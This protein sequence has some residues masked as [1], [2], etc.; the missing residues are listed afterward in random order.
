MENVYLVIISTHDYTFFTSYE[1]NAIGIME[2]LINNYALMYAF[3]NQIP[4]IN[5]N[6]IISGISPY[7]REDF[8]KIGIYSTPAYRIS[9]FKKNIQKRT[10]NYP[11]ILQDQK[12]IINDN[13]IYWEESEPVGFTYNSIEE[14]HTLKMKPLQ[15]NFPNL[16]CYYKIPPLS[17]FIC[18]T[19]GKKPPNFIRLGK[20]FVPC[21]VHSLL[22]KNIKLID[23]TFY[24]Y[25]PINL[26]ELSSESQIIE[27]LLVYLQPT[28]ILVDGKLKGKFIKGEINGFECIISIPNISL[29]PSVFQ[30]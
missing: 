28:S 27:G 2:N 20:K 30:L 6:R 11:E 12:A 29:Y 17:T 3:N 13:L 16:G 19:I 8:K 1:Y 24:P 18:F 22:I 10:E 23:G 15:Y 4:N 5:I 9:Q 26:S 14:S 7:Y 21:R 25:H